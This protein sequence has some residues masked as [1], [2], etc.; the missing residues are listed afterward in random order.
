LKQAGVKSRLAMTACM[1]HVAV[2]RGLDLPGAAETFDSI[3]QF[4]DESLDH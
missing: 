3:A 2:V 4:M 1:E